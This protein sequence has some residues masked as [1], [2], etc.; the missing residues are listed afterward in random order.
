MISIV[1]PTYNRTKYLRQSIESV[2]AQTFQ[3]WELIVVDDHSSDNT[4][5]IVKEYTDNDKRVR[6]YRN[7]K[8][9]MLPASLNRGFSLAKGEYLTWTSDDN[10]YKP[11]ALSKL[12]QGFDS[13]KIG[14][15]FSKMDFINAKGRII[16]QPRTIKS[17]EELHYRNIVLASFLYTREAYEKVGEYDTSKVLVEDFDYWIRLARH[18]SLSYVDESLYYYRVHEESLTET[19]RTEALCAKIRLL[20]EEISYIREHGGSVGLI[21]DIYIEV[22]ATAFQL[23]DYK[24]LHE[25]VEKARAISGN[26]V[27]LPFWI[28][29]ANILGK[30]GMLLLIKP[31]LKTRKG[32]RAII[33]R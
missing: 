32:I 28:Q 22:A 16:G 20:E 18:F 12:L 25:Y 17:M 21:S 1:L 4:Y 19:M 23:V 14:L 26:T 6:Y 10:L 7:E 27:K 2:L 8:H 11:E 29:M 33:E 13:D 3:D 5:G 31:L 15:V 30:K 9:L 24:L